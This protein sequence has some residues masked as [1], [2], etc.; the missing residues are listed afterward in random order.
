MSLRKKKKKKGCNQCT[1]LP[2]MWG[3]RKS[4]NLNLTKNVYL[5]Q[6][7]HLH[8]YHPDHL[9]SQILYLGGW[10]NMPPWSNIQ[11]YTS[12]VLLSIRKCPTS[13]VLLLSL[14][15][16][17]KHFWAHINLSIQYSKGAH[18][19]HESPCLCNHLRSPSHPSS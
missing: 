5:I 16:S 8:N 18:S 6:I 9:E 4:T 19:H 15:R 13:K 2:P 12:R 1:R 11:N 14:S 7:Y 17:T 10:H 3:L